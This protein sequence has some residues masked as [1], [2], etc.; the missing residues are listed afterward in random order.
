VRL[1]AL[2]VVLMLSGCAMEPISLSMFA[3]IFAGNAIEESRNPQP[4]PSLSTFSATN[5]PPPAPMA[6]ERKV[7]EQDCT[8]PIDYTLGNIKCK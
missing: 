8:K 4:M 2:S 6:P 1:L 7:S 3:V 5:A